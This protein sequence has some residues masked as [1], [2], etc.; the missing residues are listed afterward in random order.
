M[1]IPHKPG[2][3]LELSFPFNGLDTRL[4]CGISHISSV[5]VLWAMP[6]LLVPFL[7]FRVLFICFPPG[8]TRFCL[9]WPELASS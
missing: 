6:F 7:F 3:F 9:L 2:V 5:A 8:F 4:G 1:N